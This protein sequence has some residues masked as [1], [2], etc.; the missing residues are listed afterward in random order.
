MLSDPYGDLFGIGPGAN[1]PFWVDIQVASNY[2]SSYQYDF[3]LNMCSAAWKSS[4]G[5]LPCPGNQDDPDGSVILLNDPVLETGKHENELTLW[6]RPEQSRGGW[7]KGTYPKYK[8]QVGDHFMADIGC[9]FDN[10]GCDVTFSLSYQISGQGVQSLGSWHEI[11]DGM[12]KRVDVD[13]SALVGQSVQFILTVTDNGKPSKANAFWLVPSI[14]HVTPGPEGLPVVNA[15]RQAVS[16]DTGIPAS[17]LDLVSLIQV[18]WSDTCLGVH[19]PNQVCAAAVIPGY[20]I[21]LEYN[22]QQFEVHTNQD[23]T[24]VFWFEL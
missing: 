7:I 2:P 14:Q 10:Q 13:L 1:K 22:N 18:E 9:L 23:G 3:A 11:Y 20:R 8:V 17:Q 19:L 21:I 4:S 15:A 6:T 5:N 12:I 16:Q 24:I